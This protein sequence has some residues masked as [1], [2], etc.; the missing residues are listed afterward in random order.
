MTPHG[1]EEFTLGFGMGIG[2][3]G[4]AQLL[5]SG[6][7]RAV[8]E[9]AASL[10]DDGI[11]EEMGKNRSA[12]E[13]AK[14][15]FNKGAQLTLE[16]KLDA[17]VNQIVNTTANLVQQGVITENEQ[18]RLLNH[19][20]AE[21]EFKLSRF[22]ESI[23]NRY[24]KQLARSIFHQVTA[25]EMIRDELIKTKREA[26]EADVNVRV[27]EINKRIEELKESL[28]EVRKGITTAKYIVDDVVLSREEFRDFVKK[29]QILQHIKDGSVSVEIIKENLVGPL[30]QRENRD[31]L[32]VN[33][34][35]DV[36]NGKLPAVDAQ[37][38]IDLATE[39]R[40]EAQERIKY[41]RGAAELMNQTGNF[42]V[43]VLSNTEDFIAKGL[44]Y[45]IAK[46]DLMNRQ[47]VYF[48]GNRVLIDESMSTITTLY[49][50]TLHPVVENV[51][52]VVGKESF[53]RQAL[54][55]FKNTPE[56]L[57]FLKWARANYG[58]VGLTE[59]L[60]EALI[61]YHAHNTKQKLDDKLNEE[62]GMMTK[63][64]DFLRKLFMLQSQT[65]P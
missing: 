38:Y 55:F 34:L 63:F 15:D 48:D 18:A 37:K 6:S 44:S 64:I 23:N 11:I 12:F 21:A 60:E 19:I 25:L 7:Q 51:I 2:M 61:E 20:A 57:S 39:T 31:D 42:Q 35:E 62:R 4:G 47:G 58:E 33:V 29:P 28:T 24:Q 53:N 10:L 45:G 59:R 26:N 40:E 36:V 14:K 27:E 3:Q 8:E 41:L 65:Y 46:E 5:G 52:K 22:G 13:Q 43:E 32:L 50:E 54:E 9:M 49:H 56:A 30:A 17:R 16:E 1:M